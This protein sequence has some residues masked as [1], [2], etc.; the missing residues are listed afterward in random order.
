MQRNM[1]ILFIM[2]T[3]NFQGQEHDAVIRA[4]ITWGRV[5]VQCIAYMN[6]WPET[7][8]KE[9]TARRQTARNRPGSVITI[10]IDN[11]HPNWYLDSFYRHCARNPECQ[12]II[13]PSEN[14]VMK[15]LAYNLLCIIFTHGIRNGLWKGTDIMTLLAAPYG[16]PN[17]DPDEQDQ[18]SLET[19]YE[20]IGFQL[21]DE[22]MVARIFD[23]IQKCREK[24]KI[25]V[26]GSYFFR[27]QPP[28]PP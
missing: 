25:R 24:G 7:P 18:K 26:V 11:D 13:T 6:I 8:F 12:R 20:S 28:P 3:V 22:G 9:W 10:K 5:S 21:T 27:F 14:E 23:R 16:G 15:G 2:K 19:F 1:D 4:E 17:Y